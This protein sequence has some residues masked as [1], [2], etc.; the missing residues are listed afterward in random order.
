MFFVASGYQGII[1]AKF[2]FP[3]KK[4]MPPYDGPALCEDRHQKFSTGTVVTLYVQILTFY[5]LSTLKC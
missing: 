3:D 5:L 4:A 2:T 1:E